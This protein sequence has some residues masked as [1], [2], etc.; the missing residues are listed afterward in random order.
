MPWTAQFRGYLGVPEDNIEPGLP[1][2]EGP[3]TVVI[4]EATG[5]YYSAAIIGTNVILKMSTLP[6]VRFKRKIEG[7]FMK[8]ESPWVYK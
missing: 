1:C 4:R 7:L 6:I 2:N 8:Q 3:W 5:R